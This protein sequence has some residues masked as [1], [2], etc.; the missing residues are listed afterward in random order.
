M[1]GL[2][3]GKYWDN[4]KDNHGWFHNKINQSMYEQGYGISQTQEKV[5][6]LRL[7]IQKYF[8]N[9]NPIR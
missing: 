6:E 8:E 7:A 9:F 5:N 1:E 4:L 2:C 3:Q